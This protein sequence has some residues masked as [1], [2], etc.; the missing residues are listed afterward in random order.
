[1]ENLSKRENAKLKNKLM[2]GGTHTALMRAFCL[3]SIGA[4]HFEQNLGEIEPIALARYVAEWTGGADAQAAIIQATT[5][6]ALKLPAK[7]CEC[8]LPEELSQYALWLF[9]Q[10]PEIDW[11]EIAAALK[12][13]L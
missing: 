3:A 11:G 4:E 10:H 5:H 6:G 13:E 8:L 12:Q 1:M 9:V 7:D 2:N